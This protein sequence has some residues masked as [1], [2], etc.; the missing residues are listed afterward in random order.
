[1]VLKTVSTT[2]NGSAINGTIAPNTASGATKMATSA[3]LHRHLNRDFLELV[4]GEGTYLTMADGRKILD[5]SGGAAVGCIGWGNRR[6]AEAIMEQVLKAPYCST[7]FYTTS[8][9]EE[10]CRMLVDSTDGHM[11][12]AYIVNSGRCHAVRF[13][14]VFRERKLTGQ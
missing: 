9:C 11:A 5:A 12:R 3:V 6:V 7:L 4:Q 10:L 13:G 1:M 2:S 8:V 14:T